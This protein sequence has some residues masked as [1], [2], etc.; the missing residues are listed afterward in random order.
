MEQYET[1]S[2]YITAPWQEGSVKVMTGLFNI[3]VYSRLGRWVMSM[4]LI[5]EI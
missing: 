5:F 1:W 2:I 4:R 3:L